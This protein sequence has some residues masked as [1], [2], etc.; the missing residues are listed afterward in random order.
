MLKALFRKQKK[1]EK[2][3][4]AVTVTVFPLPVKTVSAKYPGGAFGTLAKRCAGGDAEAMYEMYLRLWEKKEK[5]EWGHAI[6]CM[7]LIRA[8]LYGNEKAKC[9]LEAHPEYH[10]ESCLSMEF[11]Q[12][13]H[14]RTGSADWKLLH[15]MGLF[16][17][18]EGD[19]YTLHS[20]NSDGLYVAE[21][22]AGY[23]GADD[24]GFGMEEEY[25]YYYFDEFFRC[26]GYLNAWSR[27]DIRNNT[28]RI[29][30]E[31]IRRRDAL[32]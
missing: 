7:W 20:M 30:K 12:P 2:E 10:K 31:F 18:P 5:D 28:E 14:N 29:R 19:S 3:T 26:L 9:V 27:L 23:E 17:F 15:R 32:R 11:F 4:T 21:C 13:G 24:D 22:Y 25:N 16:E 1:Q 6:A 8:G